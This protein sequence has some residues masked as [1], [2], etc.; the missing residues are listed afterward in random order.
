MK[1][2]YCLLPLCLSAAFNVIAAQS[3]PAELS[4]S[5]E[6][7]QR[8]II[9]FENTNKTHWS[10]KVSRFENEEGD[11]SSSIEQHLPL[12]NEP[13]LLR[14]IDG[15]LPTKKQIK[16]FTKAKKSQNEKNKQ[17]GNIQLP[18][19]QLINQDSL[20][21]VSDDE[22]QIVMAFT[23]DIKKLGTDAIGKLQGKLVYQKDKK[24]I[25]KITIWN[26]ADFSPMFTA[27]ITDLALTFTF[28]HIN[29]AVLT[30]ENEMTMK[31]SFAYFT[32]INETSI[33]SFSE[34]LYQ[35]EALNNSK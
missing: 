22:S 27:N 17:G 4:A 29:G 1:K 3:L 10:Y 9:K 7:V 18:L 33:D 25:E 14:Q 15:K 12:A 28:L 13:W 20:S 2:Y 31:G 11:I 5:K 24:F 26:N 6:K 16:T 21:L 30:K 19:S 34:Y 35:G 8:A 23:V 32:E